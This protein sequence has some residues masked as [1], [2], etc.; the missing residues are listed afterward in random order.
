MDFNQG[1]D[2]KSDRIRGKRG[3]N[4]ERNV[5]FG[6]VLVH[7]LTNIVEKGSQSAQA[8]KVFL[9]IF[10][11][12]PIKMVERGMNYFPKLGKKGKRTPRGVRWVSYGLKS[13]V[14]NHKKEASEDRRGK[15]RIRGKGGDTCTRGKR[16]T[17]GSRNRKSKAR[18]KGTR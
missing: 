7:I 18:R 4:G 3:K 1:P 8:K 5:R 11:R 15:S 9:F 2:K 13:K 10:H 14:K 12:G 16:M 6:H 17:R